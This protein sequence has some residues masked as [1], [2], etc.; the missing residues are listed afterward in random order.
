[1]HDVNHDCSSGVSYLCVLHKNA[2]QGNKTTL[3]Q[4]SAEHHCVKC[5]LSCLLFHVSVCSSMHTDNKL[6]V[7]MHAE[8]CQAHTSI[9]CEADCC[10]DAA[11]GAEVVQSPFVANHACHAH[12]AMLIGTLQRVFQC[13]CAHQLKNL[14]RRTRHTRSMPNTHWSGFISR[15]RIEAKGPFTK[16]KRS[17][18][19]RCQA[20]LSCTVCHAG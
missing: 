18:S 12:Y 5:R 16:S 15:S 9:C 2:T 7:C 17:D 13:S 6:A 11:H 1:M 14:L 19:M 8:G 10:W 4:P 20:C 3:K